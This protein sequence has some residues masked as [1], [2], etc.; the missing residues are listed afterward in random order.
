MNNIEFRGNMAS[1]LKLTGSGLLIISIIIV[2]INS[3][4]L[5]TEKIIPSSASIPL[6]L[7][8]TMSRVL[9]SILM[10]PYI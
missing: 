3:G 10:P 6:T 9:T 4:C 8:Q 5:N 7:P 1:I 2:V